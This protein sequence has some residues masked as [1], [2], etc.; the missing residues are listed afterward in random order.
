MCLCGHLLSL[1]LTILLV[2]IASGGIFLGGKMRK[3]GKN[4]TIK[5]FDF[6][7]CGRWNKDVLEKAER[8]AL[9]WFCSCCVSPYCVGEHNKAIS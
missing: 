7:Y 1:F 5:V 9:D 2:Q 4:K 8:D 6:H 3:E